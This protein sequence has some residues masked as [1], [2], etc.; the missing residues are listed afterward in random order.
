MIKGNLVDTGETGE[1]VTTPLGITGMP[2]VR[3]KTGDVSFIIN[4]KCECGR[5]TNRLGSIVGRKNQ[6]LKYK[7]TVL[8]PASI[9]SIV[10]GDSR[11]H[12]GY[13][14]A[15]KNP[16][17]TDRVL[18]CTALSESGNSLSLEKTDWIKEK[19]RA[20]VRVTPEIK[21]ISR[22][23]CDNKVYQFDKKR[24]REIFFDKR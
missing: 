8:F 20:R 4:E 23:E 3:F 6:M 13:I 19:I 11:F 15:Y 5:T 14:E 17:G 22:E 9:L 16:D 7:G 2:L 24:K 12:G 18:L 21:L 10:E 1:V